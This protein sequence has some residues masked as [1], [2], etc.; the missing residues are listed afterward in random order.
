M[1]IE[2]IINLYLLPFHEL[3]VKIMLKP[4]NRGPTGWLLLAIVGRRSNLGRP[5]RVLAGITKLAGVETNIKGGTRCS[6]IKTNRSIMP[7]N[8]AIT[9]C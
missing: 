7:G 2:F 4:H 3:C 5:F 6:G 8:D 9:S 1:S